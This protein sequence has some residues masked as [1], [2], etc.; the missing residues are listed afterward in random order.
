MIIFPAIDLYEGRA[1]RL[2][3]GNYDEMTVYSE[4][5][6]EIAEDF[7]RSGATHIHVVDLEGAK[8][9][10]T[11]NI[12]IISGIAKNHG[13]FTE[14]GGGIRS[15]EVIDKY[16]SNGVSRVILGTAAV[17]EKGF[18]E[19]AVSKYGDKIAIGVDI[20]DGYVAIRG[21]TE[22]SE[23]AAMDFCS[24]MQSIGVDNII[25]TDIS[26][27]GAMKGTNHELYRELAQRFSL[28][29]TASGGVSS[30]DDVK[31]LSELGIY[32]A[33]IGKAYYTGAISLKEAIEV[34][35]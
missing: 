1:V 32:G 27:D 28:K 10:E 30:I 29:V 19:K 35:K 25:C 23:I 4:N 31:K 3:K 18:V 8:T 26:R 17:T 16:V 21:W 9:G 11:L 24:R 14:V 33:I 12:N 20:K 7:V 5:P 6:S 15:M 2:F 22:K 34:A 13:L